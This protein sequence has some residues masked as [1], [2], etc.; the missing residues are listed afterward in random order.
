MECGSGSHRQ[1]LRRYPWVVE[2]EI[3]SVVCTVGLWDALFQ[4]KGVDL[5]HSIY[6]S[7]ELGKER[8]I[9]PLQVDDFLIIELVG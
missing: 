7:R 5:S 3:Y 9:S 4:W 1:D 8:N 2:D 6:D